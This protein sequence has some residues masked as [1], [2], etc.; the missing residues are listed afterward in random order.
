MGL[1]APN[2]DSYQECRMDEELAS[3]HRQLDN[4]KR[5]LLLVEEEISHYVERPPLNLIKREREL[6]ERIDQIRRR[7]AEH[8]PPQLVPEPAPRQPKPPAK[9]TPILLY[10][11][12]AV[13]VVVIGLALAA[14]AS[15][16][17][18]AGFLISYYYFQQGYAHVEAGE[19]ER[20]IEDYD[21]AIDID[22]DDALAYND[23][24]VAY[25]ALGEYERAIEDYDRAIE[26]DPDFDL[27]YYGRGFA[28]KQ[29]GN[30]EQA[31]ADFE[32]FLEL[33]SRDSPWR[34]DA[35]GHLRDLGAR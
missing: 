28:H 20:A 18:V 3:L 29:L 1:D 35:E 10:A 32:R 15:S 11:A 19:Y 4:C 14:F 30:T 25:F 5:N 2:P 7:I 24:G 34:D 9:Q 12:G 6:H 8:R 31:I 22:P 21:R 17:N 33:S 23:R 26:I 27:P 16:G 13:A